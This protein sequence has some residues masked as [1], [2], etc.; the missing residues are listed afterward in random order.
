MTRRN[1]AAIKMKGRDINTKIKIKATNR[2][3]IKRER[4]RD[5]EENPSVYKNK[6]KEEEGKWGGETKTTRKYMKEK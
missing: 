3:A 5:K 1:W 4:Q 2:G 6:R